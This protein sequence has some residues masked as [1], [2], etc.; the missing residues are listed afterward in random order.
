MSEIDRFI[1][2]NT[3]SDVTKKRYRD[4]Y[5][6]LL[7]QLNTKTLLDVDKNL[8]LDAVII[9]GRKSKIDYLSLVTN[10]FS[11][12]NPDD[13]LTVFS[14]NLKS[15]RSSK[16][17]NQKEKNKEEISVIN[18]KELNAILN[19]AIKTVPSDEYNAIYVLTLFLI[20][21]YNTRNMDLIITYV[22]K[23]DL[24]DKGNYLYFDGPNLMYARHSYKTAD[25]YGEKIIKITNPYIKRIIKKNPFIKLNELVINTSKGIPFNNMTIN[26][27]I[28]NIIPKLTGL[29]I[30]L[31]QQ[32]IYKI[33]RSH[34]EDKNSYSKLNKMCDNRGHSHSVAVSFYGS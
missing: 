12:L 8:I 14:D 18:Y 28:G 5:S 27:F 1:E 24:D 26:R 7:K 29:D 21:K 6:R 20:M 23:K 25:K 33:I 22:K 16:M 31:N 32:I 4:W 10:L 15:W 17:N 13:D 11:K 19:N 3:A 2:I 34:F 30:K 9:L